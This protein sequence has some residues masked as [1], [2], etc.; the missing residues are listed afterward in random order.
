[1]FRDIAPFALAGL[2]L[3]VSGFVTQA[4]ADADIGFE[5][6]AQLALVRVPGQVE[7]IEREHGTYEV[8]VRDAHGVKFEVTL[9]A[10]DGKVLD[11]EQDD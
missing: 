1:M 6:A 10:Q 9:S 7:S 11:V 5:R 8:E 3:M 2:V 4:R